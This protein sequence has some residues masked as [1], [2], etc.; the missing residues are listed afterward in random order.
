MWIFF[1][2]I[3]YTWCNFC[4][5]GS[6]I[7]RM[8]TTIL[9]LH[10]CLWSIT[11]TS[12]F[13]PLP[14]QISRYPAVRSPCLLCRLATSSLVLFALPHCLISSCF[15]LHSSEHVASSTSVLYGSLH[16]RP[17]SSASRQRVGGRVEEC[18]QR[19]QVRDV[20]V[21]ILN[22]RGFFFLARRGKFVAGGVL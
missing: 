14:T 11:L 2:M 4:V 22:L 19:G 7:S 3:G 12:Y 21:H 9:R 10:V 20:W 6:V 5:M 17:H 18:S 15:S 1:M 13:F 16:A 8:N